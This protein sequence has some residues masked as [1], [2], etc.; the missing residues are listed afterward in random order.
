MS[1]N[2]TFGIMQFLNIEYIKKAVN[3]H[4]L[5]RTVRLRHK[6]KLKIL[7]KDNYRCVV[8]KT[9]EFLTIDHI[10]RVRD[11]KK[12]RNSNAI[13]SRWKLPLEYY[14]VLCVS[15]HQEKNRIEGQ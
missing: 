3:D 14:Q 15:C 9:T 12:E 2:H 10:K 5:N 4:T 7:S 11:I 1:N 13:N 8:C 6:A